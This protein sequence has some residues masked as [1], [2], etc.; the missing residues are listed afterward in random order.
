MRRAA[1]LARLARS[2]EA[3]LAGEASSNSR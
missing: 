1:I 3:A 2:A